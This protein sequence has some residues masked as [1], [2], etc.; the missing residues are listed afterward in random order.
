M[1]VFK[2]A[3][4]LQEYLSVHSFQSD[5]IGFV[6]TMGALH[7]GHLELV[8][9]CL[10]AQQVTVASIFVNP[11]QFNDPADFQ[12][13]PVTIENDIRLLEASGCHV[14]FLPSVAEI[15]PNGLSTPIHYDLGPLENVLEGFYRPGHFQG[16]CQVVNR[17]LQIVKPGHLYLGRK[18]YQ[19]CMVIKKMLE[20]TGL[21]VSVHIVPTMREPDGLAMSSR[22]MRLSANEREQASSIYKQMVMIK[23]QVHSTPVVELEKIA[24]ANLLKDGFSKVDYVSIVNPNTLLP[25]KEVAGGEEAIV[26]VAA[27]LNNV[28]LI[29]NMLLTD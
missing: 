9:H 8:K 7:E 23:D 12:K 3:A 2:T 20:L 10:Q 19:Q 1:I 5:V 26:L 17:L 22:N 29:D 27:F 24:I 16:V 18:D 13:Y 6:P 4:T 28:R 14:L 15:Y 25:V 11:T 21:E